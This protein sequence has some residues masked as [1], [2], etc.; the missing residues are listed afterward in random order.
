[1]SI[2][3]VADLEQTIARLPSDEFLELG[4]WF[5]EQRNKRWNAQMLRDSEAGD[6]DFLA[7]ELDEHLSK[8]KVKPLHKVL[9]HA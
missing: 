1:M 4:R 8:G 7:A 6:L 2:S 3:T 5:D 9:R